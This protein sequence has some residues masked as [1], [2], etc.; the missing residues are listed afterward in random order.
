MSY[1][2]GC[3]SRDQQEATPLP[4]VDLLF[5]RFLWVLL[6]RVHANWVLAETETEDLQRNAHRRSLASIIVG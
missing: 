2:D 6:C 4:C 5:L 3:V 1:T